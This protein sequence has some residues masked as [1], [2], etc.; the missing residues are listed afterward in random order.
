MI[1]GI[2]HITLAVKDVDAS[3]HFYTQVLGCRAVARWPKGAYLL[4]GNV[5]LALVWDAQVRDHVFP[6]YTH[7][8][9]TVAPADF[10]IMCQRIRQAGAF[11]WQ[12]NRT[13]GAS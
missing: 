12:D 9:W 3:F 6:E 8:A 1:T 13:E 11:I 4:A 7:L 10:D 5:W 2:N